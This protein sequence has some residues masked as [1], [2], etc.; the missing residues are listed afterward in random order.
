[1]KWEGS[2]SPQF[3]FYACSAYYVLALNSLLQL[4]IALVGI[5]KLYLDKKLLD[6]NV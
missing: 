2:L 4:L 1:M 6:F 3:P 5:G